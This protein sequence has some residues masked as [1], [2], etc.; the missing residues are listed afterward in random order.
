MSFKYS[1]ILC[2]KIVVFMNNQLLKKE[3]KTKNKGEIQVA[4]GTRNFE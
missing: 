3:K 1:Y 4:P 2:G